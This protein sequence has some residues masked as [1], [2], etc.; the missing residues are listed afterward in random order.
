MA[1]HHRGHSNIVVPQHG[2][3]MV[4]SLKKLILKSRAWEEVGNKE[5][6]A[7]I[8]DRWT[9]SL[10]YGKSHLYAV[11]LEIYRILSGQYLWHHHYL[12]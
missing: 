3:P 1:H 8:L 10:S 12:L 9:T 2:V 5:R 7:W 11:T 6:F 4:S